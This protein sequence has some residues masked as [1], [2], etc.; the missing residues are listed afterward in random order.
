MS[1]KKIFIVLSVLTILSMLVAC[2]PAA[3]QAPVPPTSAPQIIEVTKMVE[4]TPVKEQV[5]VTATAAPTANPYDEN[6]KITVWI[7]TTRQAAIDAFTK[8][9]PDKAKLLNVVLVDRG[10]FPAKVLLFNNTGQGWPDVVFAESSI[11]GRTADVAHNFPL[12]LNDWVSKDIQSGFAPGALGACT[13]D[14]HLYCLRND[15]AQM[16][17]YYNK[18]LMDKFGYKVPTTWEEYQDLSDSVAKDHPGYILGSFG[19]G[20]GFRTY[21]TPAHCPF[22]E[23]LATS[24]VKVALDDPRCVKAAGL[25]DH[26]LKNG[27][28]APYDPF[29]PAFVKIAND[30]KLLMMVAASWFGEYI[31]SGKTDGLYYKTAEK[32]LG[33]ALPLK[34]KDQDKAETDAQ[35]G[36]A[37]T[38]SRHT[39]NPQLAV[40][41]IVF[42]TTQPDYAGTGPTFPAYIPVAQIW[43]KTV[44]NNPLY[45]NGG[46]AYA[47]WEQAAGMVSS[48][49]T[50]PR[51]DEIAP[52]TEVV[53]G[54][55]KDKKTVAESLKGLQDK[56]VPLAESQ[57]YE[58]ITK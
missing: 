24:Q 22:G 13:F 14:G 18:P 7:D 44:E 57:G 50:E 54:L 15:L 5:V 55:L 56:L 17:L 25:V 10:Q 2:A 26:M 48:L 28:M 19:D 46:E 20:W 27:T 9:Y 39:K 6:A 51:Y 42:I 37:W 41:L 29:D 4:G 58:V 35:G 47:V 38:V 32:Q 34:W 49:Y 53:K 21:F 8:K 3:T 45:V 43:K 11:V 23:V 30:N 40:D 1:N 33:V 16:V 52:M 12:D 31:F 36:A